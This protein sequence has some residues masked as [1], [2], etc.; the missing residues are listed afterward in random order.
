MA[1]S[2]LRQ[3]FGV[4]TGWFK[5]T[6]HVCF[7][8]FFFYISFER[9]FQT[10]N[11]LLHQFFFKNTSHVFFFSF[12]GKWKLKSVGKD[13]GPIQTHKVR[14]ISSPTRERKIMC[15][16]LINKALLSTLAN[17]SFF[18]TSD[19]VY[20]GRPEIKIY[21]HHRRPNEHLER[22]NS[23]SHAWCFMGHKWERKCGR[24]LLQS[25]FCSKTPT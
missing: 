22:R 12:S 18:A 11:F 2:F 23:H 6:S 10:N 5:N 19:G 14:G 1:L 8:F 4:C 24:D 20:T 17:R 15:A 13:F 7:L 21:F 25:D 3:A 9:I 16:L